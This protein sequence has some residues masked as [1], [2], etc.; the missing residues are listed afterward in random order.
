MYEIT[1]NI[2]LSLIRFMNNLKE[3]YFLKNIYTN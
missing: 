1:Y 3:V 2:K